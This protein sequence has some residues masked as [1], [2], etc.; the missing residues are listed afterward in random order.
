[1]NSSNGIDEK[2]INAI[3]F[4]SVDAVE[5]ANSGHPGLPMGAAAMAY[6]LW[7]DFLKFTPQYPTWI[8]RDRFVLS[9]GHGSML[10]YSLLH[11][12]GYDVAMDD[13]KNFRQLESITPGHPEY[14]HTPGVE[15]TTGPLGQGFA[16]AV[17]MAIAERKLAAR[18]NT[19]GFSVIDHNTYVLAGDGD[20]MEGISSEAASIAGH[21]GLGKLICL[22][23]DNGITIDGSTR[24]SFTEDVKMRFSAY[25]WHVMDVDD[26][27]DIEKIRYAIEEA[28]Y[29]KSRPSL[30]AV[31][32][33][34]GYGS[35]NK[36][37]KAIAHGSPLGA[38]EAALSKK[39]LGWYEDRRFY[40]PDEVYS[41][42]KDIVSLKKSAK[43]KWDDTM[44][45]YK[46]EHP[47]KHRELI[48]WHENVLEVEKLVSSGRLMELKGD[49]ASR[50]TG[51]KVLNILKEQF[52]NIIGGSADLNASTKTTLEG[53]GIFSAENPQG[54]NIYFGIREHAMGGILNGIALHGG[55]RVFGSTFLVFSDYMRPSIRLAALMGIPVVFVFTHDSIGVGED[56]PTH[57]PVE[58]IMSLR[59][60]PNLNVYRPMDSVETVYAWADAICRNDGP[61]AL[62]LSRQKLEYMGL[63]DG[64]ALKGAYVIRREK[65]ESPDAVLMGS[66]SE[67][68]VLVDA[69]NELEKEGIDCRVISFLSF[70]KFE[71]QT[72]AY[73]KEVLAYGAGVRVS[74]EAGITLGWEKY[75]GRGGKAIGV[76]RFGASAPGGE[77]MN[78]YGICTRPVIEAVR[79]MIHK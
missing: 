79:E 72:D 62:I 54:D 77:L 75:V 29:E 58:H 28:R 43:K 21:L 39:N 7:K 19:E 3:R 40:I 51:G 64:N 30:I 23:D 41:H 78:E 50:E 60:I 73:R 11:L 17:G 61:S 47:E 10:L 32:N 12:F 49:E 4:L 68:A 55:Y 69:A 71:Q 70:E 46:A 53:Y 1:M 6:E 2:A 57:Q 35:P 5:K 44:E 59:G 36:A 9:A 33:I 14:G 42:A 18:F 74:L 45:K 26:G 22:Y 34:I 48:G 8:D 24:N 25:G 65:G 27:N 52:E 56:G 66:G 37:G 38:D 67:V 15:T 20:L 31:K 76:D 63:S 16:N 13:I